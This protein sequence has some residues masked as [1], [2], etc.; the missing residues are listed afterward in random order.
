MSKYGLWIKVIKLLE[1]EHKT[2][3]TIIINYSIT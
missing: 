3:I 2:N 1:I